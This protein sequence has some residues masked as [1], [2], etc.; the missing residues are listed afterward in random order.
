MPA[1]LEPLR[2]AKLIAAASRGGACAVRPTVT[3]PPAE[4]PIAIMP[5][6]V[7]SLRALMAAIVA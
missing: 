7:T 4:W 5:S 2:P 3:S 6:V 1:L